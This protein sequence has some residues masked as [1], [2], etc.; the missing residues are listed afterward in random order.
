MM[1]RQSGSGSTEMALNARRVDFTSSVNGKG[2]RL[3]ISE[4]AG[5]PPEGGWPVLYLIDGSLHFGITVDTARIQ[6]RWPD[7]VDAV[8]VG[9]AYQTDSVVKALT[10]RNHDLTPPTSREVTDS[11]WQKHMGA[12]PDDYGGMDA[13]LRMIEEEAKPRVQ[14]LVRVNAA[15]ETLMGH[16][17]GGLTTLA[18][19]LRTPNAFRQYVAISPSIWVNDRWVLGFLDAFVAMVQ[20]GAVN[21]RLLLSAGEFEG[22]D[23]PFPPLPRH[24]P[25]MT[26]E[27][28]AEMSRSC[29]MTGNLLEVMERLEPLRGPR[30]EVQSVVHA[31]E[32]HRSVVPAGIARG[33]YFSMYRP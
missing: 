4:P 30:F 21:A 13:F 17:L 14:E 12:T 16:S 33:I 9:I 10:V 1:S 26:E 25:P 29:R 22:A 2:Y 20:A 3:L 11:G 15:D 24:D 27:V 32:D 23:P 18:T 7:T 28:Y 5:D 31:Q 19:L 6:A 8:I